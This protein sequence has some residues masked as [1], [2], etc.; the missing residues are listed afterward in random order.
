M[1]YRLRTLSGLLAFDAAARHG[2]LTEAAKEL[3]R[4]QSAVSQQVKGFEAEIGL[5]LFV[6]RPREIMLTPAGQ[7][8]ADAVQSS[9]SG[10]NQTIDELRRCCE[11]NVIQVTTYHS[12]AVNWLVPR[13]PAF[14]VRHPELDVRVNADDRFVDL[15]AGGFDLAVQGRRRGQPGPANSVLFRDERVIPVYAPCLTGGD[16]IT[17]NEMH[18][19]PLIREEGRSLWREWL[20]NNGLNC[21]VVES[22]KAYSHT[23][24][25]V[26][27]ATV[28]AGIALIPIAIAA[29]SLK[30]GRLKCVRGR[31]I[32]SGYRLH[33]VAQQGALPE[34]IAHFV[35]WFGDELRMMDEE[36]RAYIE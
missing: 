31:H 27:A 22:G 15:V 8:L 5:E 12:F 20:R 19:Y 6:R 33:L 16:E 24:L 18:K 32:D 4:T 10:I 25:L 3:G 17:A 13:L 26:Q 7:R 29:E 35:D 23:G 21:N 30:A 9:L 11:P 2:S 28:G 36:M 34:K 14:G 1:E